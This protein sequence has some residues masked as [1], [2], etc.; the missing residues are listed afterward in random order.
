MNLELK[1]ISRLKVLHQSLRPE[2]IYLL[3][4][5]DKTA[6]YARLSQILQN[7]HGKARVNFA[8]ENTKDDLYLVVLG[9]NLFGEESV[10]IAQNF[11][12]DKK[13][14]PKDPIFKKIPDGRILILWEHWQLTPGE[15]KSLA[16]FSHIES[17]KPEP[18]IFRFLDSLSP[19]SK[20]SLRALQN[21]QSETPRPAPSLTRED[22][23][24]AYSYPL[25]WHL[26]ART[27][28]LIIAKLGAES[29]VAA[30]ITGRPLA[31]WQ[32]QKIKN[33]AKLFDMETLKKF[34]AGALKADLM[35]KTAKTDLDQFTISSLLI[36]KYLNRQM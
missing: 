1:S 3:H 11:I 4:G 13:L 30:Q 31:D 15:V 29:A 33:Q 17:F 22:E 9:G 36:L 25:I 12:R 35:A 23:R 2:M 18:L 26:S 20:S 28:Y 10:V 16:P 21:L 8:K 14:T 19:N 7:Y 34:F 5:E 32:W 24:V 6:S 27:L